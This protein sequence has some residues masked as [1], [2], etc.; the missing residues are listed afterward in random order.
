MLTSSITDYI[1]CRKGTPNADGSYS[2]SAETLVLSPGSNSAWD[3]RHACDPSVIKGVFNY[4]GTE[5]SYLMAYLGCTSNDSQENKIGLAVANDPMGPFVRVGTEPLVDFKLDPSS[6]VFQWGVG[7]ASL[8]S[9]DKAGKVWLFYTRGEVSGTKTVVRECDFSNLNAPVMSDE[10]KVSTSGLTNLNGKSD[11]MNNADFVYD[12]DNYR[13][14]SASDSH[15]NPSD[16]PNNI[17]STFRVNYFSGTKLNVG[18]WQTLEQ[19]GPDE[20]GWARN[21]NV[22]LVRD[23]YG[24][25]YN[26][27]YITVYYTMS[28]TGSQ[29]LWSYRIY[30][31]NIE[32]K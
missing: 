3:A 13:F 5:Y 6:E 31:Y 4:N 25:L 21:H 27:D 19:V 10:V 9:M 2:W 15:P 17:S 26:K 18:I 32:L 14:Y 23:E 8:V 30:E 12:P 29:S 28:K 24:H 16:E 11:Y 20:T 22:G 7:Q 1:G